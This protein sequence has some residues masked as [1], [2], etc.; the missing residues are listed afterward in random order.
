MNDTA[1]AGGR[2]QVM[3]AGGYR[4][5]G[6]AALGGSACQLANLSAFRLVDLL[7]SRKVGELAGCG[8]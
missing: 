4:V 6:L 8:G 2:D 3:G 5:G 1:P 7:G